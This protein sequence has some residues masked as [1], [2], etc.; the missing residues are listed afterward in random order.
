M[1]FSRR[2]VVVTGAAGNL[3]TRGRR[4]VRRRG[5]NLVLVGARV[6]RAGRAIRAPTTIGSGSSPRI[7]RMQAGDAPSRNAALA[8][9]AA[10]TCCATSPA[11][12]GWASPFTRR[13]TKRGSSCSTLN[14]RSLLQHGARGRAADART[15]A[16]EASSTSARMPRRRAL[17]NMGAYCASKAVVMRLTEAMAAELREHNINVNC[18]LPTTIDTPENRAAMPRRR[19]GAVGGARGSRAARSSFSHRLP[20]ARSTARRSR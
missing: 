13:R 17:A 2:T 14:V 1:D 12:S 11:D 5:A 3:G 9:S 6:E 20:R 10:S 4:R 15:A 7:L 18:V 19:S 16:A 8:R